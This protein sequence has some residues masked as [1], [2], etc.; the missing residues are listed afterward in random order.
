MASFGQTVNV[1]PS[2]HYD[3]Y[4][5]MF[6]NYSTSQCQ[7]VCQPRRASY[8]SKIQ[9]QPMFCPMNITRDSY[10]YCLLLKP[11]EPSAKS[12]CSWKFPNLQNLIRQ[13]SMTNCLPSIALTES[14]FKSYIH[15]VQI[16]IEDRCDRYTRVGHGSALHSPGL[17]EEFFLE[18]SIFN[19]FNSGLRN[20]D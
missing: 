14:W 13:K 18:K 5:P 19:Q 8:S 12:A 3:R 11:D 10:S 20:I 17:F 6:F 16:S 4:W 2:A 15:D 9:D 1:R 7:Q